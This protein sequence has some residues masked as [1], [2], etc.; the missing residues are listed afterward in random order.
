MSRCHRR[1]QPSPVTRQKKKKK[2]KK[3]EKKT[4][5]ERWL[6]ALAGVPASGK[7]FLSEEIVK[8]LNAAASTHQLGKAIVMPM[9]GFHYTR[10]ELDKMDD[11]KL[12]HHRRGA[13]WTFDAKGLG[14]T[15]GR[16]KAT[17]DSVPVPGFDHKL[18]DPTP[19]QYE[20]TPEHRI[21]VVE[22]LYLCLDKVKAWLP[23][24]QH[25]HVRCFLYTSFDTCEKR[26]VPRHVHAGIAPDESAA[27]QRWLTNDKVNAQLIIESTDHQSIDIKIL[28]DEFV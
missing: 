25:F 4:S 28:T 24:A 3:K 16:I 6:V 27:L 2:K 1:A 18:K 7:S 14:D 22:G 15:L 11:P 8:A 10:A 20:I 9:D 23:V 17:T 21:V 26:I 19:N 5:G 13:E 12:A